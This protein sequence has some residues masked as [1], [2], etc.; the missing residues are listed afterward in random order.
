[1]NPVNWNVQSLGGSG[2]A[3]PGVS[4]P[5]NAPTA[6]DQGDMPSEGTAR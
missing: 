2:A 1:M 5:G 4:P 3:K 6:G